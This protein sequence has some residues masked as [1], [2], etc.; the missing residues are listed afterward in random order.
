MLDKR[1]FWVIC[2]L[3]F[4]AA[5]SPVDAQ[6]AA[7]TGEKSEISEKEKNKAEETKKEECTAK[8]KENR[9]KDE[10]APKNNG[11]DKAKEKDTSKADEEKIEEEPPKV[12]NFTLPTSQQP[13]ALFG[14]GGNIIDKGEVQLYFFA[15]EFVGRRKLIID[16]IPSVLFGITDD[17]SIFFNFPF[18]PIFKD[19]CHR[20][21]GLEDFFIQLEYAFYNKKTYNYV[22]Q[23]T[24]VANITAPTG[25]ARKNPPTGLGSPSLFLGGTYYR[26]WVDWFVFTSDGAILTTS[27][28]RTKFGDQF[29]YQFGLGRN[30]LSSPDM[31]YAWM[32]EV[33]GQYSKKNRISGQIDPN[34]GGNFIYVT[35]SLWISSKEMLLQFGVSFPI[36]QNLFGKQNKIDYAFNL[37]FAWSFYPFLR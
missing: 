13:A 23:A 4:L 17:W 33:D 18:T 15:D 10:A 9:D 28:N 3:V 30:I 16:L 8:K 27:E 2:I 25:S 14:F 6:S 12:G 32:V 26:V 36:T 7:G 24:L 20:S 29:L 1:D 5:F 31:I 34:S 21:S 19:G 11:E 22:D 35:P 37:N